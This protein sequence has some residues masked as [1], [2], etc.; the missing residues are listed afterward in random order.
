MARYDLAALS[1][2][3]MCAAVLRP[4][5]GAVGTHFAIGT[6]ISV[7][8]VLWALIAAAIVTITSGKRQKRQIKFARSL[9]L[10]VIL[11]CLVGNE[12]S[13]MFR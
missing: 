11:C 2:L 10:C 6:A 12:V 8:A 7:A 1:T 5:L 13:G 9:L 4:A 3:V